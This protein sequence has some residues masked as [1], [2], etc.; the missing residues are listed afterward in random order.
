MFATYG[1]GNEIPKPPEERLRDENFVFLTAFGYDVPDVTF[2]GFVFE[3]L[4]EIFGY[5]IPTNE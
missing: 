3:S 2:D 1:T 4:T 5:L